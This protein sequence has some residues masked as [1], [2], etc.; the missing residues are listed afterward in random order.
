MFEFVFKIQIQTQRSMNINIFYKIK[1][2]FLFKNI[3]F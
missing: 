2:V 3:F 1:E